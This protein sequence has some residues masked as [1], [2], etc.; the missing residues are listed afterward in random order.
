MV[1]GRGNHREGG[2]RRQIV[3]F[4]QSKILTRSHEES[5]SCYYV[6]ESLNPRIPTNDASLEVSAIFTGMR[7]LTNVAAQHV[8][9][10]YCG[11]LPKSGS[12]QMSL[13]YPASHVDARMQNMHRR[14]PLHDAVTYWTVK[15]CFNPGVPLSLSDQFTA[16]CKFETCFDPC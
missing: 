6:L 1:S 8:K 14:C 10:N 3:Y 11:A 4:P 9:E 16:G 15:V 12:V 5:L 7:V 13:H 2:S